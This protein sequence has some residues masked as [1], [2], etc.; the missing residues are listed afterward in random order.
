ME[1]LLG[2][3]K[4][5]LVTVDD[6]AGRNHQNWYIFPHFVADGD[7]N[8]RVHFARAL[9]HSLLVI[10]DANGRVIQFDHTA[11]ND[12]WSRH[13]YLV[14]YHDLFNDEQLEKYLFPETASLLRL[15]RKNLIHGLQYSLELA[16]ADLTVF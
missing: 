11:D 16:T 4:I 12:T 9:S 10:K 15:F 8:A 13:G 14:L 1:R 5:T 6:D 2:T 3:N 7:D